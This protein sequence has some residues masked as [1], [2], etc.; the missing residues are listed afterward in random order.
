MRARFIPMA[1]CFEAQS[2]SC[3]RRTPNLREP[4]GN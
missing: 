4:L 3:R 2:G 1:A